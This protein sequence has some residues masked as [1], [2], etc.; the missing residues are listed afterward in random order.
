MGWKESSVVW[1]WKNET[2]EF[3]PERKWAVVQGHSFIQT[4]HEKIYWQL[5]KK[6]RQKYNYFSL[7]VIDCFAQSAEG[8]PVP[9]LWKQH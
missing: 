4:K 1:G 2:S 8:T 7:Y 6:T 3:T 5:V 9:V